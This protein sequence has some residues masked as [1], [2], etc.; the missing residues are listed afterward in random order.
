[1]PILE[2][3]IER[4]GNYL[5]VP[6]KRVSWSSII[7]GVIVGIA[8]F[9]SLSMLGVALGLIEADESVSPGVISGISWAVIGALSLFAGGW[10][11]GR[12]SGLRRSL[13]GTLHGFVTWA[14]ASLALLA[15]AGS[16]S[17]AMHGM[18]GQEAFVPA[19]ERMEQG[20]QEPV[21]ARERMEIERRAREFLV[22]D[23][24]GVEQ[25]QEVFD[26]LIPE[27]AALVEAISHPDYTKERAPLID[28]LVEATYVERESIEKEVEE[29]VAIAT[30]GFDQRHH[31]KK[32]KSAKAK[33]EKRQK[34]TGPTISVAPRELAGWS[35]LFVALSAAAAMFGGWLG[36]HTGNGRPR[37]ERTLET[38]P[39]VPPASV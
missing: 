38:K 28:T 21:L 3:T 26:Q 36:S 6:I 13:E 5:G 30:Q 33:A 27:I 8:L 9:I 20:P 22:Q 32:R 29:W 37:G 12:L 16:F 35:F 34:K 25:Q 39:A 11:A 14:V 2:P 19:F 17:V 24:L 23:E 31:K 15:F 1:M 7:S 4:R 18:P 10:A